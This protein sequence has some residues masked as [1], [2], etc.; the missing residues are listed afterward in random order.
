MARDFKPELLFLQV[1][2][3]LDELTFSYRIFDILKINDTG[4]RCSDMLQ[5]LLDIFLLRCANLLNLDK[6]SANVGL[7]KILGF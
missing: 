5:D 1:H 4:Y 3:A 2:G 6:D 7:M